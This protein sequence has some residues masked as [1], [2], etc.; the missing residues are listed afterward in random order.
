MTTLHEGLGDLTFWRYNA[1]S[2]F[3][4]R[5]WMLE[6]VRRWYLMI[7][8]DEGHVS[9]SRHV[10]EAT[11]LLLFLHIHVIILDILDIVGHIRHK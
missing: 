10:V 3:S 4:T 7:C 8:K 2:F 5:V 6:D 9:W 11:K 1:T